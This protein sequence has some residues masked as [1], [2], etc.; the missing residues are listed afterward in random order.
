MLA[1][2]AGV[3]RRAAAKVMKRRMGV[4]ARMVDGARVLMDRTGYQVVRSGRMQR[5]ELILPSAEE[6]AAVDRDLE[7]IVYDDRFEVFTSAGAVRTYL[8]PGR[9]SAQHRTLDLSRKHGIELEGKKVLEVG[10]GTGYLLRLL[11]E[12]VGDGGQVSGVEY[13]EEVAILARGLAPRA[14]VVTG[15]LADMA[16]SGETYDVVFCIEV[17]EHILD[18]ETPIPTMLAMLNPGGTLLVSVPNARFDTTP[19]L[20]TDDGNT[21][22]GHV[23]YWTPE[24]WGAYVK[25]I[26]GSHRCEAGQVGNHYEGDN[27]YAVFHRD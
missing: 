23:N 25:R 11:S 7:A 24:S 10:A 5:V 1:M 19:A 13:F 12:E 4:R 3:D 15:S 14:E 26:A 16:R 22:V 6:R 18:T 17:L 2:V 21:Y 27:L 9:M 8:S 20:S